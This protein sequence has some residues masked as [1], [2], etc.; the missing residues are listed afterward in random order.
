M[1]VRWC[2]TVCLEQSFRRTK[3]E[4]DWAASQF[5]SHWRN[6]M[7][8]SAED[9]FYKALQRLLHFFLLVLISDSKMEE[10]K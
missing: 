8:L 1:T 6:E 7:A 4:V 3:I 5:K 2:S 9:G 10:T